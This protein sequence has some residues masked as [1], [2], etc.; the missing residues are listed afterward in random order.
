M[1]RSQS[2]RVG[3]S[4]SRPLTA[5]YTAARPINGTS[6]P[7]RT[8]TRSRAA[9]VTSGGGRTVSGD[10]KEVST[11][12]DPLD[13]VR[14]FQSTKCGG[15]VNR[16]DSFRSQLPV[17]R[18]ANQTGRACD[19]RY[20]LQ[21][22]LPYSE[23][24]YRSRHADHFG[25]ELIADSPEPSRHEVWVVGAAGVGKQSVARQFQTSD[26]TDGLDC[27]TDAN[28]GPLYVSVCLDSEVTDLSVTSTACDVLQG[29]DM[30][31]MI[32]AS[33]TVVMYSVDSSETFAIARDLCHQ[34]RSKM[35]TTPLIL[36]ANKCDL[37]RR[38]QVTAKEGCSWAVELGCKYIETSAVISANIDQLLAGIV[39][40][41]RLSSDDNATY[42]KERKNSTALYNN[43][44]INENYESSRMH[45][46]FGGIKSRTAS[47]RDAVQRLISRRNE[48]KCCQ[49]LHTR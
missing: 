8:S 28:I 26:Y 44:E 27:W 45:G 40:Q 6:T 48:L 7:R 34:I 10:A 18:R 35:P 5:L 14:N 4:A 49:N 22:P 38:R 41:C 15:I 3:D 42:K 11:A 16:G 36:V 12:P 9:S 37:V 46:K 29:D 47:F 2:C 43:R 39:A 17:H 20:S 23:R 21:T 24:Y 33:V 31:T 19:R 1:K 30:E 13:C 32:D 25:V